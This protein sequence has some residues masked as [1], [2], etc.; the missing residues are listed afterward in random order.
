MN[1][2][3]LDI[4]ESQIEQLQHDGNNNINGVTQYV[5]D[6]LQARKTQ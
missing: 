4:E 2:L 6:S 3:G 1:D 5:Y